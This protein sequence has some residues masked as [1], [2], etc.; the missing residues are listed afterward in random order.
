MNPA[1]GQTTR[2][3]ALIE[4]RDVAPLGA[5]QRV[6]RALVLLLALVALL[7]TTVVDR[8]Y[9]MERP[10]LT[11]REKDQEEQLRRDARFGDGSLAREIEHELQLTSR[12]RRQVSRAYTLQLYRWLDEADGAQ[13]IVGEGGWIFVKKRAMAPN[14]RTESLLRDWAVRLTALE[15]GLAALGVRVILI[16]LPRRGVVEAARLPG[17]VDPRPDI[18]Q[19]AARVLGEHGLEAV[20]LFDTYMGWDG[21]TLFYRADAH[22]N[23]L[24]E[25]MTA[26]ETLRQ[27]GMLVAH[28]DRRGSLRPDGVETQGTEG[29]LNRDLYRLAGIYPTKDSELLRGDDVQV[30]KVSGPGGKA[31]KQGESTEQMTPV[32]LSGTSFSARRK[33]GRFL[34]YFGDMPLFDASTMAK[35]AIEPIRLILAGG[36]DRLPEV[37][38]AEVPV[39]TAFQ[40]ATMAEDV[41]R[42][43]RDFPAPE[44]MPLG[45]V[46]HSTPAAEFALEREFALRRGH[47]DI[48]QTQPGALLSTWDYL[49]GLRV[50]AEVLAGDVRLEILGH[51]EF[52]AEE[53]GPGVH[54]VCFPLVAPAHSGRGLTVRVKA[55]SIEARVRFDALEFVTTVDLDARRPLTPI[56][57]GDRRGRWYAD[58][59]LEAM[60]HAR[61]DR[62]LV[63]GPWQGALPGRGQIRIDA[64]DPDTGTRLR[65]LIEGPIARG[66]WILVSLGDL[67]AAVIRFSG[68]GAGMAPE[69][70]PDVAPV[71]SALAR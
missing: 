17:G 44:R 60:D 69:I 43:L 65:R 20:D 68:H 33:F 6:L 58:F 25:Q 52:S 32:A 48:L 50:Q 66:G 47:W 49:F 55:E 28:E 8:L 10:K 12:V 42:L 39:Y 59:A 21:P 63:V 45:P 40:G 24:A 18:D 64:V 46:L 14:T 22:W 11:G 7:G 61:Q 54:D 5:S 4:V 56:E 13:V 51:R 41:S 57:H 2:G 53:W 67:D 27:I 35:G 26:E 1:T 30:F 36:H 70:R 34:E 71:M 9:P 16:P 38:L 37:L 62:A 3:D 19:A 31:G 23:E 15:R 29:D